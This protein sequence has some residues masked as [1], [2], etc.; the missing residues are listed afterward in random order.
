MKSIPENLTE[1]LVIQR[2]GK[3]RDT[4]S[5]SFCLA[6]RDALRVQGGKKERRKEEFEMVGC[7][8]ARYERIWKYLGA[9]AGRGP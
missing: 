2:E 3:E 5:I 6:T 9:G 1:D 7:R 4:F 8:V